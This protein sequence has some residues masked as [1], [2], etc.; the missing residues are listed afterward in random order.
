MKHLLKLYFQ[1]EEIKTRHLEPATTA[2]SLLPCSIRRYGSAILDPANLH[3]SPGQSSQSRLGSGSG[4]LGAVTTGGSQLDVQSSDPKGFHL[5]CNVLGGQH[6]GVG[7]G[8]VSVG[9]HLHSS[10]DSTDGLTARQ[11]GHVDEGVVEGG[12]DVSHAEHHLSILHL[13]TQ[14]DLDLFLGFLLSLSGCHDVSISCRSES[15][16]RNIM[17]PRKGKK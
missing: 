12:V 10:G 7:R 15:R 4:S 1:N 2:T 14:L 16:D 3:A 13:R 11:V 8:L 17:A 6:S 5:L 9:L